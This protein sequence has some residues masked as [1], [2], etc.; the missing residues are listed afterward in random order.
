MRAD[1]AVAIHAPA[2]AAMT[3]GFL[4]NHM[5]P[6]A[7]YHIPGPCLGNEGARMCGRGAAAGIRMGPREPHAPRCLGP[8][9]RPPQT[10]Q[11]HLPHRRSRRYF[12]GLRG[13]GGLTSPSVS[14]RSVE[15]SAGIAGA[16]WPWMP[17][18]CITSFPGPKEGRGC[19]PRAVV[20]GVARGAIRLSCP[21]PHNRFCVVHYNGSQCIFLNSLWRTP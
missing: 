12:S 9:P 19:Q 2:A 18:R 21:V 17:R 15:V 7:L 3:F 14:S 8:H 11:H 16:R 5:R 10:I 13:S 20:Q 4:G 1:R 6:E